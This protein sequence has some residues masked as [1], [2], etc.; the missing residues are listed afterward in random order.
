MSIIDKIILPNSSIFQ[1]VTTMWEDN[2]TYVEYLL[3]ILKKL[4]ETVEQVNNNTE[5]IGK[6]DDRI[7]AIE[8]E[9][10]SIKIEVENFEIRV[11]AKIDDRLNQIEQDLKKLLAEQSTYL[12]AY[13]DSIAAELRQE[14]ENIELGDIKVYDPT[15]GVLSPLQNVI[16]NIYDAQRDNA[17]TAAEFDGLQKTCDFID[18][19]QFTAYNFDRDGK[20]IMGVS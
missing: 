10:A 5:F 12:K 3:G 11:E 17:I 1:P 9:I 16:N 19:L 14:I 20:N 6:Y 13:T 15:S 7:Q 18:G 2:L 8:D 4:N